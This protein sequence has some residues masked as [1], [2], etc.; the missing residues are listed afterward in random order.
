MWKSTKSKT[1]QLTEYNTEGAPPKSGKKPVIE[2][3]KLMEEKQKFLSVKQQNLRKFRE[4]GK[5]NRNNPTDKLKEAT[6]VLIIKQGNYTDCL[7]GYICIS[8]NVYKV[9]TTDTTNQF[10][11]VSDQELEQDLED[12]QNN[13]VDDNFLTQPGW[14]GGEITKSHQFN[15]V[16]KGKV[17]PLDKS[18]LDDLV[19]PDRTN[20]G[21]DKNTL[22]NPFL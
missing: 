11:E 2:E 4:K 21:D 15:T 13:V 7:T 20:A 5:R 14:T 3:Q 18:Q 6:E 10:E 22:V 9:Y 12:P 17:V 1:I 8:D 19:V 16:K